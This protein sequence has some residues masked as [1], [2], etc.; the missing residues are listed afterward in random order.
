MQVSLKA[1]RCIVPLLLAMSAACATATYDNQPNGA[2]SNGGGSLGNAGDP[3]L[4]MAG[5]P[6][7][8]GALGVAGSPAAGAFSAGGSVAS[9]GSNAA[10]ASSG[11]SAGSGFAGAATVGGSSSGGASQAGSGGSA[12]SST[13]KC[14]AAPWSAGTVYQMG[15]KATKSGKEYTAA[16]YTMTD[17][18][19]HCCGGGQE[20]AS[21]VPCS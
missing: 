7:G 9:G 1:L 5:A 6:S 14:S 20:W 12:G 17:P 13:G 16:Y 2:D 10:G 11:G 19:T 8:A 18:D 4:G 15:D 3:G 21:M